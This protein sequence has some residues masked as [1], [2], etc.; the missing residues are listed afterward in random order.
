MARLPESPVAAFPSS[1][2]A[3]SSSLRQQR[4]FDL[5]EEESSST[6]S[7]PS[8]QTIASPDV[9][10]TFTFSPHRPTPKK[11]MEQMN[12]WIEWNSR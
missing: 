6:P 10:L 5:W 7:V 1:G 8:S 11:E 2:H 9:S 3:S 4:G 12:E